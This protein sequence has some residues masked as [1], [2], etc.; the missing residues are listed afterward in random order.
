MVVVW[1]DY[2][3]VGGEWQEKP[4]TRVRVLINVHILQNR[5]VVTVKFHCLQVSIVEK[6]VVTTRDY[7]EKSKVVVEVAVA[8]GV[9][10]SCLSLAGLLI[11]SW[12]L[13]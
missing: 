13:V 8:A 2:S 10:R 1:V 11:R 12:L 9:L 4:S 5:F 6:C 7:L 3:K